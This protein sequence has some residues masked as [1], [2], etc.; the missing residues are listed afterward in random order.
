[1]PDPEPVPIYDQAALVAAITT[2]TLASFLKDAFHALDEADWTTFIANAAAAHNA[3][4]IDVLAAFAE[5]PEGR[6]GYAPQIFL[7]NVIPLLATDL[8]PLTGLYEA[9]TARQLNDGIGHY[10]LTGIAGWC[11][12]DSTRPMALADAAKAGTAPASLLRVALLAGLKNDRA[13]FLPVAIDMIAK[14]TPETQATAIDVVGRFDAFSAT[15]LS[16]VVTALEAALATAASDAVAAPLR[17]LL[18]I[19]KR[20]PANSAVG[21]R[22]IAAVATSADAGIR[23]TIAAELMA[24]TAKL[25]PRLADAAYYLLAST[26]ADEIGSI[27]AIDQ[28][29]AHDLK[30]PRID[31]ARSLLDELLAR[32]VATMKQFDSTTRALLTGDPLV[33]AE[34]VVRWLRSEKLG[35]FLAVHDLCSGFGEDA[36][37]FELD[38]ATATQL[39]AERM[40]RRCCALLMVFPETIASILASLLRTGP[41]AAFPVVERLLFDPLLINYWH[42]ARA[43]LETAATGAP[44]PMA[45]VLARVL[46][47]HDDYKAGIEGVGGLREL[48]PSQHHRFLVATKKRDEE[49]AIGKAAQKESIF[50]E[51]FPTSLLLYGDSVIFDYHA[52][53]GKSLRQESP[54]QTHEFSHELPRV[55]VIDPFWS[56]YQRQQ[57]LRGEPDE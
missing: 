55:D 39:E 37:R 56:W 53:P 32:R 38:F 5:L 43:Y 49:R 40:A 6:L 9:L 31:A 52:E 54:M 1:M 24:G 57:L 18:I 23:E 42:G 35:L 22:A 27:N 41:A 48:R 3:G 28:L 12:A 7:E 19:A 20:T 45:D 21:V 2:G 50:A 46:K 13:V 4:D 15:E 34:I 44:A 30:S 17:S 16:A 26:E 29:I 51:I 10:V 14:G 25:E 36:T 33:R 47:R 11:E 8:P